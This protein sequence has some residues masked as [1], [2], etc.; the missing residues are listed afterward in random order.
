[1][2]SCALCLLLAFQV[3]FPPARSGPDERRGVDQSYISGTVKTK[4]GEAVAQVLIRVQAQPDASRADQRGNDFTWPG[5]EARVRPDGSFRI[6]VPGGMT[7]E[8]CASLTVKQTQ[9]RTV[10][11]RANDLEIVQFVL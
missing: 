7:Y 1:M 8:V 2:L 4:S 9:C 3:A 10:D 5:A 11:V 6:A